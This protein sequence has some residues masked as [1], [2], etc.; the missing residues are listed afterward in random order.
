MDQDLILS[1]EGVALV[2][3]DE[4]TVES[5]RKHSGFIGSTVTCGH[6]VWIMTAPVPG[7]NHP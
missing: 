7:Y 5:K 6:E 3:F 2:D 4:E 1:N